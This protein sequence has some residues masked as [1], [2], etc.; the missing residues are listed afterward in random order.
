MTDLPPRLQ[1]MLELPF[2]DE[3]DELID[4]G[5]SI[6]KVKA[7]CKEKGFKISN[8]YLSKYRKYRSQKRVELNHVEKYLN[9]SRMSEIILEKRSQDP[10][11]ATEKIKSDLD[12]IDIVIQTGSDQL[13]QQLADGS[14][15]IEIKDVFRAIE[16]KDKLTE[17]ATYGLTEYGIDYLQ[18]I[19]EGFYITVISYLFEHIPDE[20]RDKVLKELD[21]MEEEYYKGTDYYEEYLRSKG[22]S[23]KEIG[24]RI[25][26]KESI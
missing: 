2:I 14:S 19:T 5:I 18:K 8:T 10:V 26:A 15:Y 20:K 17:G 12:F 13:R 23:E 1:D 21:K 22:Y 11:T 6:A 9:D 3:I 16:L 25:R 7:Y 4:T 24:D